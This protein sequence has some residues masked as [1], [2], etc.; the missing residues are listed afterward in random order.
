MIYTNKTDW[1]SKTLT[2]ESVE[3]ERVVA[4]QRIFDSWDLYG[5]KGYSA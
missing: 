5:E 1:E 3:V 2:L 4:A